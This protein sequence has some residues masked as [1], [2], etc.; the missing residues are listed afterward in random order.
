MLGI[1]IVDEEYFK[2]LPGNALSSSKIIG[3]FHSRL[4]ADNYLKTHGFKW[5]FLKNGDIYRDDGGKNA[6]VVTLGNPE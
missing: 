2:K 3:P 1:I 5:R 4:H 6:F